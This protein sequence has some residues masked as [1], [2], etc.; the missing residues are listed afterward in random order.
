M[1]NPS[2][3][4]DSKKLAIIAV[5]AAL[6]IGTNYAM[7][8]LYNV[9][10]MDLIVFIGGFCF[11]PFVGVLI[12]MVSWIV[13]GSLNPLGF[14]LPVWLS[15]MFSEVIYGIA[16]ALMRKSLTSKQLSEFKHERVFVSV[17]FGII[18]MF[19]TL[20]YDIVTNI[21]FGYVSGWNILW[22]VIVG[23]VPFGFVHMVSNA[24][25]FGL[26]CVPTI[27]AISKIVGGEER[28]VSE[29]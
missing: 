4:V 22:A 14:S 19:L 25:F 1:D 13:Y 27:N 20:I 23:F 26:G 28:G 29:K 10:I 9:K 18:G 16:G 24:F 7:I 15:T 8:S 12:G 21:V 17:Y 2:N 5:L 3:H 11:G 6:S